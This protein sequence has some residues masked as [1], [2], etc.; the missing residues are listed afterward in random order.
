[1][2][3]HDVEALRCLVDTIWH[4]QQ[5]VVRVFHGRYDDYQRELAIKQAAIEQAL[6]GLKRQKQDAHQALMKEQ[7]RAK[8]SR[9]GGEKKIENRK[10]PTV[11][12]SDNYNSRSMTT[13]IP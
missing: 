12:I 6:S 2:V 4:I 5:G 1:M 9:I 3:T 11:V 10:W 7:L 13:I 8:N